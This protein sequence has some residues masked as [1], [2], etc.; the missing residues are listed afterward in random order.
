[1]CQK[2]TVQDWCGYRSHYFGEAR[3]QRTV[4]CYQVQRDKSRKIGNCRTGI[5][6]C[7]KPTRN[8]VRICVECYRKR[9]VREAPWEFQR[10]PTYNFE[11]SDSEKEAEQA[12]GTEKEDGSRYHFSDTDSENLAK[13]NASKS[14][15]NAC[16]PEDYELE[17]PS[18]YVS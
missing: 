11:S 1:M 10:P 18:V 9:R 2:Q 3:I 16:E 12:S 13:G 4:A 17:S 7:T 6:P 15:S 14:G 8:P 5:K